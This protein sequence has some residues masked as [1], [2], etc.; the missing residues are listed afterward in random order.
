MKLAEKKRKTNKV[1]T[2]TD[3]TGEMEQF[4]TNAYLF[5]MLGIFPL[6]YE[7]QYSKIGNIKYEFFR[8]T[9][10]VFI[11]ISLLFVLLNVIVQNRTDK[12]SIKEKIISI[13]ESL[14]FLDYT[15]LGYAACVILSYVLSPYKEFAWKGA[16]G[17]EMGFCAQM[18]F[19]LLYF[20]IRLLQNSL[21]STNVHP[22]AS[23]L[24]LLQILS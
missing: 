21:D 20:L 6:Y 23:F 1:G 24:I 2:F 15:V 10:L 5:C 14:S 11:V 16:N 22:I 13:K 4:I 7:N 9:S 12:T 3:Y 17:W 19:V 18:I 8:N